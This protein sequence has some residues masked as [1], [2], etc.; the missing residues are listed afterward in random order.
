MPSDGEKREVT[1][2]GCL[3]KATVEFESSRDGQGKRRLTEPWKGRP[4]ANVRGS[5][6]GQWRAP[7]QPPC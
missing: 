2:R 4:P 3:K 7:P 6:E 1:G 5:L